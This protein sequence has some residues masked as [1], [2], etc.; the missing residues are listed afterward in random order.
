MFDNGLG[1]WV[2]VLLVML[3]VLGPQK[4]LL[5]ASFAGALLGRARAAFADVKAELEKDLPVEEVKQIGTNIIEMRPSNVKRRL[6]GAV[7]I[8]QGESRN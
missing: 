1:E 5:A 3:F 7:S 6:E 8:K 2:L 4:V